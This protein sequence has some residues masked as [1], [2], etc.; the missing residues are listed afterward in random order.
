M[1]QIPAPVMAFKGDGLT[2]VLA[3]YGADMTPTSSDAPTT[4][5]APTIS[6]HLDS[7][8]ASSGDIAASDASTRVEPEWNRDDRDDQ[9]LTEHDIDS[10]EALIGSSQNTPRTPLRTPAGFLSE[11]PED[12]ISPSQAVASD[13]L[14]NILGNTVTSQRIDFLH[15]V[16]DKVNTWL[17]QS[18]TQETSQIPV[19]APPL[20]PPVTP[21]PK[22]HETTLK[23]K[24]CSVLIEQSHELSAA[25]GSSS[26]CSTVNPSPG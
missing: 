10:F 14:I 25:T 16:I 8:A 9:S 2:H 4:S 19:I 13:Y 24:E 3:S 15:G 23:L 18:L 7:A 20:P 5:D 26:K 22:K 17:E 12:D 21:S 11:R 6:E 1:L